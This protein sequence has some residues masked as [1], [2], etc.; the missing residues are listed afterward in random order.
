MF[1]FNFNTN[2]T[3]NSQLFMESQVGGLSH[4]MEAATALAKL[5]Q[6]E[7][8]EEAS[9]VNATTKA[10][11]EEAEAFVVTDEEDKKKSVSRSSTN[12]KRVIFPQQLL[13]IL[14]DTSLSD[15]VTWLPHGR[16]FAII[17][18]DVFTEEVLPKYLPPVDA[19]ASTKYPSFTRK[20]N[21]W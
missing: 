11:E 12:S 14:S 8:Y 5:T 21:R 15:V 17:R 13:S 16:S 18:P 20:L 9:S 1:Q 7:S 2:K 4:L 19:R 3:M 6:S 10:E